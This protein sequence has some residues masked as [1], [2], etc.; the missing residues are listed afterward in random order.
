M[1]STLDR[2]LSPFGVDHGLIEKRFRITNPHGTMNTL[3]N[4]GAALSADV[5][6]TTS[7]WA[8]KLKKTPR[9][10]KLVKLGATARKEGKHFLEP[11]PAM[12]KLASVLGH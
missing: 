12:G 2:E 3:R 5:Q 1:Y 9:G 6:A 8:R 10:R 4:P 7:G 11:E